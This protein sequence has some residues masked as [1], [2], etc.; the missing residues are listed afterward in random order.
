MATKSPIRV[1]VTGAAGNIGYPR[2]QAA[3]AE[4]GVGGA[5]PPGAQPRA[6]GTG[7]PGGGRGQPNAGNSNA[8]SGAK[9]RSAPRGDDWQPKG[10]AAHESRLPFSKSSRGDR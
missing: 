3:Q 9:P 10:A 5:R 7:R 2:P 8:G 6:R 4:Q 1:A